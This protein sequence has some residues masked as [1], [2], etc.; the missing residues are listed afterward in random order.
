MKDWISKEVLS[1]YFLPKRGEA[2]AEH[3][4][5]ISPDDFPGNSNKE[6]EELATPKR[7][8]VVN[9]EV[10][11]K[12]PSF[13]KKTLGIMF[14][15]VSEEDMRTEIIFDYLVPTVKDTVVDVIKM[16][17]DMI[18]YGSA[19]STKKS[20]GAKPYRVSY[21]DYYD[22]K[23]KKQLNGTA[24]K[25]YNF[26]EVTMGSRADAE[27]VLDTMIDITR[28]YGAASVGD[29]CD[30]VGVDNNFTDY[31]Y[32]WTDLTKVTVS[33]TRDGYIINFPNPSKLD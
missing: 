27:H 32:G 9:G 4:I 31:K 17:T 3:G 8:K 28:E 6:K 33:R 11:C 20:G 25:S 21:S 30:L 16:V 23:D 26:D 18:F 10:K 22:S 13:F 12:K 2:M 5:I 24:K 14:A 15:D 29:F 7:E 19:R 1:F